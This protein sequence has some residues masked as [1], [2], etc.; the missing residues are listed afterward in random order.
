LEEFNT[1]INKIKQKPIKE[2][3]TN[4]TFDDL[5]VKYFA[6]NIPTTLIHELGHAI[7][8]SNHSSSYS[9]EMT[10]ISYLPS[11]GKT[12]MFE[13][14]CKTIYLKCIEKGMFVEYYNVLNEN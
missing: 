14:M 4:L 8:K 10:N 3:L 11:G 12:L 6:T 13:D 7:N 9:H 2:F 1:K 5:L